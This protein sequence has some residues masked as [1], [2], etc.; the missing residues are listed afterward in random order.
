MLATNEVAH[1][2]NVTVDGGRMARHSCKQCETGP[3]I[4][5]ADTYRENAATV[6]F[7]GLMLC[8]GLAIIV[9]VIG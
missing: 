8:L 4:N 1:R 5:M 2:L 6:T 3:G 7:W 9:Y